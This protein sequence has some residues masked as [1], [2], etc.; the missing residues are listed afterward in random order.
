M[1]L[2]DIREDCEEEKDR[3]TCWQGRKDEV[4][5]VEAIR[6][7]KLVDDVNGA[8]TRCTD[9]VEMSEPARKVANQVYKEFRTKCEIV[10]GMVE[11]I[12]LRMFINRATFRLARL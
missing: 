2:D 5:D 11:D 9:M 8:R 7:A 4:D 12:W 6:K 3:R 1:R 10:D